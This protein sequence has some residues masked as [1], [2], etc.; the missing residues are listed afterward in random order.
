AN[1]SNLWLISTFPAKNIDINDFSAVKA[2]LENYLP[3]L[4][5]I[6]E[7]FINENGKKE[8]T[9]KKTSNKWFETQDQIRY[10]KSFHEPKIIYNDIS[11]RQL[12][13]CFD[14]KG[15]LLDNTIYFICGNINLKHLTGILNTKLIDWYYRQISSQL[16]NSSVRLFTIFMEKLPIPKISKSK[17]ELFENLVDYIL[18]L[19]NTEKP[20]NDYVPNSHI[21]EL[22]EEVIDAMVM[23]LYFEEDFRAADISFMKYVKRDFP[24]L[25]ESNDKAATIHKAYQRLRERKNEIR[26]NLKLMN[27]RLEHIVMPIKRG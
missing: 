2:H 24:V 3:K 1:W 18:Y 14:E 9:R 4:K 25:V 23:E 13:F 27:I 11:K 6:G 20:I 21:I 12:T 17:Q 10:W 26:N 22:I 15:I 7:S 19:H 5:Q 8:K 16:G